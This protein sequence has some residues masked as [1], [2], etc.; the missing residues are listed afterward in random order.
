LDSE[1]EVFPDANG[2]TGT[3]FGYTEPDLV[4][5]VEKEFRRFKVS[6]IQPED[7]G[8]IAHVEPRVL[9]WKPINS[10]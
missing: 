7:S 1:C 5:F 10:F 6:S 4:A 2:Y 8:Y 9:S 3:V